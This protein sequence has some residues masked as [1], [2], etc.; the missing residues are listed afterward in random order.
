MPPPTVMNY[1]TV[2]WLEKHH[3]KKL[4][5]Q[6][7]L[8]AERITQL[9]SIYQHMDEDGSGEL[10]LDELQEA[11]ESICYNE[12]K[13]QEILAR[14][15]LMDADGSGSID[16]EE[17]VA[18]MTSD[19]QK[20]GFFNLKDEKDQGIQHKA[21]FEFATTYRRE[22]L[23]E[24][25][26][27]TGRIGR[28]E[29]PPTPTHD[30]R[31]RR[32][33][34]LLPP[35]EIVHSADV[36]QFEQFHEL[37]ALQL[38]SD[39]KSELKE[40]LNKEIELK[41]KKQQWV[42]EVRRNNE[43]ARC[44][45]NGTR[46]RTITQK[47]IKKKTS[48][49]QDVIAEEEEEEEE[50]EVSLENQSAPVK[51]R[52]TTYKSPK[53][54]KKEATRRAELRSKWG[55][56]GKEKQELREKHPIKVQEADST[57][58][59]RPPYKREEQQSEDSPA[60]AYVKR[61]LAESF[62]TNL[63]AGMAI[64]KPKPKRSPSPPQPILNRRMVAMR[65]NEKPKPPRPDAPAAA[66]SPRLQH[67]TFA[68]L[69]RHESVTKEEDMSTEASDSDETDSFFAERLETPT[70]RVKGKKAGQMK[71]T[72]GQL[73]QLKLSAYKDAATELSSPRTPSM[74]NFS[75]LPG[76]TTAAAATATAATTPRR[77]TTFRDMKSVQKRLEKKAATDRN[78]GIRLTINRT[79]NMG[80]GYGDTVF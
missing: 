51:G 21:F 15:E 18:V 60:L 79:S 5:Q 76:T 4:H 59:Q 47:A 23:L 35:T 10:E 17:F 28:P 8:D 33:S 29:T 73:T 38:V 2:R 74:P 31:H 25:I 62:N 61:Q 80:T 78:K 6:A 24:I 58:Q 39:N 42:K 69:Q 43:G 19:S 40:E 54:D 36:T 75:V 48:T 71:L 68:K 77:R 11:L 37:F 64:P 52:R 57:A 41:R 70:S 56:V 7:S 44:L 9:A 32:A 3:N 46:R 1:S 13:A 55:E 30:A 63:I 53:V 50:E 27:G 16:F 66:R 22:M 67:L 65:L 34:Y 49:A 12:L 45:K 14:F 72:Q 20:K 26:E